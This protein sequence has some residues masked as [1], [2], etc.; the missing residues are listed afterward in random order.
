MKAAVYLRVSTTGQTGSDHVSLTVQEQVCRDFILRQ[1]GEVLAVLRDE[2]RSGLD[3]DRPAYQ[4]LFLLAKAKQI[5][6]VVVYRY[7][8]LGRDAAELLSAGKL[9]ASL[10]CT[11]L[12]A[13]EPNENRL[14]SGILALLAED[15]SSRIRARTVP[16]MIFRLKEGK[17]VGQSP[18]GY[19]IVPCATGGRT[20]QPN[21]DAPL[22]CKLFEL[23]A[24]GEY[25][26]RRLSGEARVMGLAKGTDF[27]HLQ[28]LLSNPAYTGK[29]VWGR[30]QHR[31]ADAVDSRKTVVRPP[32]QWHVF[33]GLHPA[34]VDTETFK[35]VQQI[36]VKNRER[37]GPPGDSRQLLIGLLWCGHCQRRMAARPMR[38][39]AQGQKWYAYYCKG[40]TD[41]HDCPQA[42]VSTRKVDAQAMDYLRDHF[43]VTAEVLERA[44]ELVGEQ[45][46]AYLTGVAGRKRQ[47]ERA[48]TRL[49]NERLELARQ[50]AQGRIKGD[51]YTAA[52]MGYT[53]QVTSI[54]RELGSLA[55]VAVPDVAA[56]LAGLASVTWDDLDREGWRGLLHSVADRVVLTDQGLAVELSD[57]GQAFARAL[58]RRAIA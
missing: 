16:A 35:A 44:R 12:S 30:K 2:G 40:R 48:H 8:R 4:Q 24:T 53:A 23:Y 41:I 32:E 22:V 20:L 34:I 52:D 37:M 3:T 45:Q 15:E 56:A 19:D 49:T 46:D 27:T 28:R 13:T 36:L 1:E 26:L 31:H 29:T 9:L 38:T 42:R 25:S 51:I 6:A 43:T 11:L 14:V 5:D 50:L 17:W 57:D 58:A 39:G 47:L 18:T 21:G 10:G 33:P 55:G 54:A 7:D